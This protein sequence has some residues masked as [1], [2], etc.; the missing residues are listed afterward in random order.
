MNR[1]MTDTHNEV[2]EEITQFLDADTSYGELEGLV[3]DGNF[4]SEESLRDFARVIADH[5]GI[6]VPMT[7]EE[8]KDRDDENRMDDERIAR[9][10]GEDY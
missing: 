9:A 4:D 5:L 6:E 7:D 3:D 2:L 1:E 8:A 10:F